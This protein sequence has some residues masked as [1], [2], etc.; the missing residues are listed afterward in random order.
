MAS[1][2]TAGL[3][4]YLLS[5][6]GSETFTPNVADDFVPSSITEEQSP[7]SSSFSQMYGAAHAVFPSWIRSFLPPPRLISAVAPVPKAPKTLT[8]KQLK[9]ALLALATKGA[10]TDS[11]PA[12]TPN[13]LIYNNATIV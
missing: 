8:P 7:I 9:T 12:G 5:I 2:H 6:Y 1:P 3:L 10:L 11:L 13:L 4:A